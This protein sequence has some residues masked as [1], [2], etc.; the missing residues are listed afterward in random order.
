MSLTKNVI[1]FKSPLSIREIQGGFLHYFVKI[2]PNPS[3]EKRGV[4]GLNQ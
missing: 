3:L 4:K 1:S 2:S